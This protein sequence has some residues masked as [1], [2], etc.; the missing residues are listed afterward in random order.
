MLILVHCTIWINLHL[1]LQLGL[2]NGII[3]PLLKL[4]HILCCLVLRDILLD[5]NHIHAVHQQVS[6]IGLGIFTQLF[7]QESSLL[8]DFLTRQKE[9]LVILLGLLSLSHS[10]MRAQMNILD[11]LKSYGVSRTVEAVR[12]VGILYMIIA[13]STMIHLVMN[14]RR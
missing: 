12:N 14:I 2:I 9:V 1:V 7:N 3:L 4:L 5:L 10:G 6:V 8:F 13:I 11:V